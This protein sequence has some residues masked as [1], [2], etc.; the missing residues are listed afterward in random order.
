M[1][2]HRGALI[3]ALGV[4]Q[5]IS[6]GTL[7]YSIAVLG[8]GIRADLGLS[9]P[10][11]FGAFTLGLLVSGFASPFVGDRIDKYGGRSVLSMGSLLGALSMGVLALAQGPISFVVGWLIAGMAMALA[12]YDPVFA[13]LHRLVTDYRRAVTAVTL[14]GGFAS[15]AFWP[16]A[17]VLQGSIGWRGA[18]ACFALMHLLICLPIHYFVV[19][20]GTGTKASA[21]ATSEAAMPSA[22]IGAAFH[23]LA[24]SFVLSSFV[25]A[26]L[27]VHLIDV[28]REGGLSADNAVWIAA[29]IGPMQV[30]SRV[31]E[32]A[33]A[34]RTRAVVV[35]YVSLALLSVAMLL[36]AASPSN[37]TTAVAFV[38]IYG[39]SMGV[40]TIVRGTAPAEL[41]AGRAMGGLLGRLARPT[42]IAKAVA[43]LV[44]S[45]IVI[46]GMST[47]VALALLAAMSVAALFAFHLASRSAKCA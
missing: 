5:V 4:A 38:I 23:W 9:G 36:L 12:L 42:L 19:P 20:P 24:A 29:G 28:F 10:V 41:F 22:E 18:F 1:Q 47:Q 35:G 44:F 34:G 14:F 37:F 30:A 2:P 3:S 31:L 26:V 7:Y 11:L 43:P 40:M 17:N 6:W 15:T 46:I 16:I 32:Y 21:D 45:V 13:T 27:S 25:F 39:V 33:L 8:A